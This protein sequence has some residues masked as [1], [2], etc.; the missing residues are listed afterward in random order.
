MSSG[1]RSIRNYL[2][3][4]NIVYEMQKTFPN[5]K[6]KNSYYKYDFYISNK[7][8][9]IEYDGEQHHRAVFG[10]KEL[11][12]VQTNDKIKDNYALKNNIKLIRIPY[13]KK[14]EIN[15]ILDK[16]FN[17]YPTEVEIPQQE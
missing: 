6:N 12:R 14:S 2:D 1:E 9:L 4:N 17:D 10:P 5:F 15:Q 3:T 7:N 13:F 8:I 16:L 11:M